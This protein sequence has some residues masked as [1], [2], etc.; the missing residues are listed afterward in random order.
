MLDSPNSTPRLDAKENSNSASRVPRD[1]A[2]SLNRIRILCVDDHELLIQGLKTRIDQEP[3]FEF[4]GSLSNAEHLLEMVAQLRP[5]VVI[6]DLQM[7]GIDPIGVVAEIHQRWPDCRVVVLSGR[8][9]DTDLTEAVRAGVAGFF[10]K[11]DELRDTLDGIRRAHRGEFVLGPTASARSRRQN[12]WM[13]RPAKEGVESRLES[14]TD[15]EREVLKMIGD[16]LT[17]TGIADKLDRSVKTID[18]HR[19]R[20]MEKLDIHSSP[21][22]VR[23]AIREGLATA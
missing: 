17:R 21:E 6:M 7:P 3:D 22:L 8:V 19:E 23:F 15:R 1:T 4:V 20:I 10:S 11:S 13:R 5:D 12:S 18:G 2:G 16:G 14:L 9:R